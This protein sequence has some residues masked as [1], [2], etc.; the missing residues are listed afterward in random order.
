MKEFFKKTNKD[1]LDL[2]EEWYTEQKLSWKEIAE[3]LNTYPNKVRRDASKLG[4]KSRDKAEAQ[5]IA[6]AEGRHEHP[7]KGKQQKEETKMKISESQG[8]IWDSLSEEERQYRSKIGREAWDNKTEEEKAEFFQ[9][10][11][12][13]IQEASRKGSKME[14]AIHEFLLENGYLAQR[15]SEHMLQNEK[16]HIDLYIPKTRTAIEVD[17]PMHFEPVF[18]EDK[19][20]RRQAA[21]NQKNGLILASGMVLIR[22]KLDK[23]DSQRYIRSIQDKVL[24]L[25]KD[26]EQNFPEK[27]KRYFEI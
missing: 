13:A 15:H 1:R 3:K 26:V 24:N 5:K 19:L 21:D 8:K 25:I 4:V 18:G 6:I 2:Y 14:R 10:S 22:V 7:T 23:R 12:Q 27:N 20:Q 16:F 9:K 11:A 17:G